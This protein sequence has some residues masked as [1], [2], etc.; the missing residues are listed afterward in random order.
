[1]ETPFTGATRRARVLSAAERHE[2]L[3]EAYEQ[4]DFS[5]RMRQR[6]WLLLLAAALVGAFGLVVF[7]FRVLACALILV[8]CAIATLLLA[9]EA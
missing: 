3:Q 2:L 7:D 1:M 5:E 6:F 4:V 8:A 9:G